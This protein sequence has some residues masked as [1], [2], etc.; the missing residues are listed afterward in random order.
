MNISFFSEQNAMSPCKILKTR[1]VYS[2]FPLRK[3]CFTADWIY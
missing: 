1:T 2:T 3:M